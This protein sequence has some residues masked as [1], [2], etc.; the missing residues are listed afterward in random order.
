MATFFNSNQKT[1]YLRM[2]TTDGN[3]KLGIN[4]PLTQQNDYSDV[5]G[6]TDFQL[7]VRSDFLQINVTIEVM[8]GA[9]NNL[10]FTDVLR[11]LIQGSYRTITQR[12]SETRDTVEISRDEQTSG[13]W[14][15][16]FG[17][18]NQTGEDILSPE[19]IAITMQNDVTVSSREKGLIVIRKTLIVLP[20]VYLN[21]TFL[22]DLKNVREYLSLQTMTAENDAQANII[23]HEVFKHLVNDLR[24]VHGSSAAGLPTLDSFLFAGSNFANINA[25][26]A[27]NAWINQPLRNTSSINMVLSTERKDT[28]SAAL[29]LEQWLK[30]NNMQIFMSPSRAIAGNKL[31]FLIIFAD[32]GVEQT[33]FEN[34]EQRLD[35]D[36]Q[37]MDTYRSAWKPALDIFA[38]DGTLEGASFS[39]LAGQFSAGYIKT[40]AEVVGAN[41]PRDDG[42]TGTQESDT[43][44]EKPDQ[45][46]PEDLFVEQVKD[47]TKTLAAT[48]MG[49]ANI[50]IFDL[51]PVNAGNPWFSG[52][53]NIIGL[54]HIITKSSYTTELDCFKVLEGIDVNL[55]NI[56]K[57]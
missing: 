41:N 30:E 8:R 57:D 11:P 26:T 50:S 21:Q 16:Q 9:W 54:K 35:Q 14:V 27:F 19:I 20:Q 13:T 47:P 12:P 3:V 4:T 43:Q 34:Y 18:R 24:L 40:F 51:I 53:Y 6:L 31:G 48:I 38:K 2:E 37:N 45:P 7:E 25:E 44:T 22:S 46:L 32:T 23:P 28:V 29:W 39:I 52:Y 5:I 17:W 33:S 49:Q 55:S 15:I 36:S 42:R 56:N 10:A 1:P